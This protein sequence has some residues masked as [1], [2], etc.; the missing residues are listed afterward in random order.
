MVIV[1][2]LEVIFN[3]I[4]LV[5]LLVALGL[6]IFVAVTAVITFVEW[7]NKRKGKKH[8]KKNKYNGYA[9]WK[10]RT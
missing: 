3:F 9:D 8:D 10:W 6:I 7:W 5:F 2:M 1:E 4:L